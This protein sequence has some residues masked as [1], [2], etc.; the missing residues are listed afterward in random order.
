MCWR[1]QRHAG[2]V[3]KDCRRSPRWECAECKS[4]SIV[5]GTHK[6]DRGLID[7]SASLPAGCPSSYP[8]QVCSHGSSVSA[9]L[10]STL[11]M[12]VSQVSQPRV[13]PVVRGCAPSAV[14]SSS[15]RDTVAPSLAV[16][17]SALRVR[18]HGTCYLNTSVVC[19]SVKTLLGDR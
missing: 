18:Q 12:A 4:S 2:R 19:R 5:G 17:R 9:W 15:F 1:L 7:T 6:F 8:V 13:M 16:V 3:I 10:L 14:I 11:Q